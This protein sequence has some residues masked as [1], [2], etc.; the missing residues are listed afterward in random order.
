[1]IPKLDHNQRLD[2]AKS[3]LEHMAERTA[4]ADQKQSLKDAAYALGVAEDRIGALE[5]WLE[6]L[7]IRLALNVLILD[8]LLDDN[9]QNNVWLIFLVETI[10]PIPQ[11]LIV[12]SID[13]PKAIHMI[14]VR[15]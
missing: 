13:I 12:A 14:C 15:Q 9:T 10:E 1:M 4:D 8:I 3:A 2:H 5:E 6:Y 7:L 11:N